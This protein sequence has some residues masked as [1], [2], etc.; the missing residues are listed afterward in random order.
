MKKKALSAVLFIVL[1]VP[2][3]F[4]I[5][6]EIEKLKLS[7]R[8]RSVESVAPRLSEELTSEGKIALDAAENALTVVD[9]AQV[10]EKIGRMI[11]ELDV[12]ARRFAVGATLSV[13]AEKGKSLFKDD[14]RLTDI[15]DF[16]QEAKP[17]ERYECVLDLYEGG[18]GSRSLGQ[19]YLFSVTLGGYDPWERRLGFESISLEKKAEKAGAVIFRGSAN[20]AE[21]AETN[22]LIPAGSGSPAVSISVTPTLLPSI[23]KNAEI[24]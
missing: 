18:K 10:V 14:E 1:L 7:L 11:K 6:R 24:P 12:P 17:A 8:H 22:I 3:V 23:E 15:A 5:S 20:L 13:F 19:R 4:I 2:S 21:G 16:I 9:R